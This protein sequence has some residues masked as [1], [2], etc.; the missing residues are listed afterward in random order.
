MQTCIKKNIILIF[1]FLMFCLSYVNAQIKKTDNFLL[2][3]GVVIKGGTIVNRIGFFIR[4]YYLINR[5][6]FNFCFR[7]VYNFTSPGTLFSSPELMANLGLTVGYGKSDTIYNKFITSYS[8]QT[9][10][11]HSV[12]YSYNLY[13]DRIETSQRTGIFALEFGKFGIVHENDILGKS[14]SDRFRSA[15]VRFYYRDV[16][17]KYSLN[18]ILWHGN[19]FDSEKTKTVTDS[20]YP[21]RFGYKDISRSKYGKISNGILSG[22]VSYAI[23][24]FQTIDFSTGINSEYVRHAIQNKAIHDM[25]F[26]P[27]KWIK[28]KQVHY[29]MLDTNGLPYLYKPDQKIKPTEFYINFGLNSDTFY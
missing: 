11:R 24:D 19:A 25:W 13:F 10:K 23:Y 7:P 21:A 26:L 3:A 2:T 15:G 4:G 16:D 27:A 29:P 9:G 17:F 18:L 28:Y 20:D 5:F 6:Q 12:S 1:V 14:R 22:Q 8:N